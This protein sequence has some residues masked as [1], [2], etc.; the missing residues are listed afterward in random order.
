MGKCNCLDVSSIFVWNIPP[1]KAHCRQKII[2]VFLKFGTALEGLF[3][4]TNSYYSYQYYIKEL[5]RLMLFDWTYNEIL[6][7]QICQFN[8]SLNKH[9]SLVK[10]Y[11]F[12]WIDNS[13]ILK[14][15]HTIVFIFIFNIKCVFWLHVQKKKCPKLNISIFSSIFEHS[16]WLI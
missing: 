1:L 10:W 4:E 5:W 6:E 16:M 7:N 3:S 13:D 11:I 14:V 9:C 2:W 15:A 12:V 8:K